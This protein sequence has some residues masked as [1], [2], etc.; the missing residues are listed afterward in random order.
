MCHRMMVQMNVI[1]YFPKLAARL[2]PRLACTI[3]RQPIGRRTLS[4]ADLRSANVSAPAVLDV[5]VALFVAACCLLLPVSMIQ[6]DMVLLAKE[7]SPSSWSILLAVTA[8]DVCFCV[9]RHSSGPE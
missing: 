2:S 9:S 4:W 8:K 3:F 6:K 7:E 1:L 5:F